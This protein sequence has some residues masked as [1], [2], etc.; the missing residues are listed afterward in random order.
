MTLKY[1]G[2]SSF[3]IKT[4]GAGL[5]TD[6]YDSKMVGIHFPKTEANIVTISH[7]HKDHDSLDQIKGEPLIIDWPGEFEKMNI[8]IYGYQSYH[9][10]NQGQERGE[11]ILYK[12]E[13][14][15]ITVLHCGDLGIIPDQKLIDEIGDVDILLVPVGGFF[16]INAEEA[17]EFA[18]MIEPSI[19]IPMH[20][21][22]KLLNQ[23]TFKNLTSVD[24]FLN[25][26]GVEKKEPVDVLSFKKEDIVNEEEKIIVMKIV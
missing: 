17:K 26:F 9:D 16:T 5:V 6:P 18:H 7:H 14:E 2:H 1:L 24:E 11:N 20:Y 15:N 23:E 13:A 19:I 10:K 21:N 22:S 12:I 25:K 4:K 3:L 8:R